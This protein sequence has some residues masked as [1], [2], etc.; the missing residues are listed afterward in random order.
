MCE[1][2]SVCGEGKKTEV[3]TV[4]EKRREGERLVDH[5]KGRQLVVRAVVDCLFLLLLFV[6]KW[7]KVSMVAQVEAVL[8]FWGKGLV[9]L[10]GCA[11]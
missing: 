2:V 5:R 9:R 4:R 7:S 3:L 11:F 8:L 10:S 1:S 6:T